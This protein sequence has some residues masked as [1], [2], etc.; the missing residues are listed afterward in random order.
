MGS[1]FE[2]DAT[3]AIPQKIHR[4]LEGL[5]MPAT[6]TK[7]GK[8]LYSLHPG[9]AR[10]AASEANLEKNTGKTL[11]EW[12][13]FVKKSGPATEKER[14][15]WL[16]TEHN[17][18]TNIAGWIAERAEGK[19]GAENYNPEAYVDGMFAGKKSGLL[20]IY[21]KLLELGL[22]L[23]DDVKACPCKTIVPLYR[24]HVFAEIKPSTNS[25]IDFGFSLG[26]ETKAK[27]RLTE[28]GGAAKGDR[29]THR[30]AISDVSEI[31]AEVI[32]WLEK[33]YEQDN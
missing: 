17:L 24:K 28:T 1:P 26:K 4:F 10:D 5:Q 25:R 11:N 13:K 23:G 19:G 27:G 8:S 18:G 12:I 15:A 3:L 16:K 22:G 6:K 7:S 33:A 32:S 20:P 30:I 2:K 14:A 29:I 31:D 9:F 21:H